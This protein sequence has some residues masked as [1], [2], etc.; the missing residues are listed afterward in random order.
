[1]AHHRRYRR[2]RTPDPIRRVTR[3]VGTGYSI[4]IED[5]KATIREHPNRP[6]E[7][8]RRIG[9]LCSHAAAH[10]AMSQTGKVIDNAVMLSGLDWQ[11]P[12]MRATFIQRDTF[13]E[14]AVHHSSGEFVTFKIYADG[15]LSALPERI[16]RRVMSP[17]RWKRAEAWAKRLRPVT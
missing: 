3:Y 1:L 16:R 4:D 11:A 15:D 13:G 7:V 14:P 2:R 8:V 9:C 5:G 10:V 12:G 6:I 17:R